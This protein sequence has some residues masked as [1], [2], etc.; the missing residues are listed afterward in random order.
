MNEEK[1][2]KVVGDIS[3]VLMHQTPPYL[4]NRVLYKNSYWL[5][6]AG[7]D[8]NDDGVIANIQMECKIPEGKDD[9]DLSSISESCL[10]RED[11]NLIYK[12][13]EL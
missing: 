4:R 9:L 10:F 6:G 8:T 13:N 3:Y 5:E 11:D 7:Y 12:E 1:V 2:I